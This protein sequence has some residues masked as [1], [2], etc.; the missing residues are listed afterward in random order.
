MTENKASE[1]IE[2]TSFLEMAGQS[3]TDAQSSLL[4]GLNLNSNIVLNN[5]DLEIKVTVDTSKGKLTVRPVS[6][7]EI[8]TAAIDPGLL[9]TLRI[10]YVSTFDEPVRTPVK[11]AAPEP[12]PSR[13]TAPELI[14]EVLERKDIQKL[15]ANARDI[16]VKPTFVPEK[17]RWLV[18]V[19]DKS[20]KVLQEIVLPD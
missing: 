20:G 16:Q 11:E 18:S 14:R 15:T 7:E 1:N 2:M 13:K 6:S 5:A 3:F 10:S 4:S 19:E 8:R 17:N 12:A 9:S